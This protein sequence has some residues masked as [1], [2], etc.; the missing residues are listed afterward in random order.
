MLLLLIYV[1]TWSWSIFTTCVYW[2][3]AIKSILL[4]FKRRS[5]SVLINFH[6][7]D[8]ILFDIG[9]IDG[10]NNRNRNLVISR[11]GNFFF[12]QFFSDSSFLLKIG[13]TQRRSRM[14]L[15]CTMNMLFLFL[16]DYWTII[17]LDSII[18]IKRILLKITRL[19]IN[20]LI[21]CFLCMIVAM[22][23]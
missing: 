5:A 4:I 18:R 6:K 2:F 15:I 8:I 14:S 19:Q 22:H 20:S 9:F 11:S 7:D 16:L 12:F 13:L 17:S 1:S 3:D 10:L 21:V 23:F